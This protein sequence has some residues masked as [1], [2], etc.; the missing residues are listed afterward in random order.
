VPSWAPSLNFKNTAV[1]GS[2]AEWIKMFKD[3][4]DYDPDYHVASGVADVVAYKAA[5]EKAGTLDR[6]A[7][8]DAIANIEVTTIYGPVKFQENGQ[9]GGG[10]VAIQIQNG[11]VVAVYPESVA[12]TAPTYPMPTWEER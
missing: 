9:I 7:V 4:Y 1:F 10:T 8:R 6:D 2:T 12:E 5:I 11:E 3:K